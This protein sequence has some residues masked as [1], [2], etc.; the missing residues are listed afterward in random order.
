MGWSCRADAGRT[1]DAWGRACQE[2]TGSSNTF[3]VNGETYFFEVSRNE[4]NDGRITGSVW[5]FVDG[6]RCVRAGNFHI[7]G[8]GTVS[9]APAFLKRAA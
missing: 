2:S 3:K 1:L 8:D 6:E 7:E 5:R 9:R 4:Y